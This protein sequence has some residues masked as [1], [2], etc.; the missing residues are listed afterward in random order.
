MH[1]FLG[2]LTVATGLGMPVCPAPTFVHPARPR[3]CH[4][5]YGDVRA[6]G[7]LCHP[8]RL[9]WQDSVWSR[10]LSSQQEVSLTTINGDDLH[11]L[12]LWTGIRISG[13]FHGNEHL[14][15]QRTLRVRFL[16]SYSLPRQ[17][18]ANFRSSITLKHITSVF[19]DEQPRYAL[20]LPA[21]PYAI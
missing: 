18:Q 5:L 14:P 12:L 13:V 11:V 19:Y 17:L 21:L 6:Q 4:P 8:R 15:Y 20:Y 1:L 2:F 9:S 10:V 7:T 3:R 16:F